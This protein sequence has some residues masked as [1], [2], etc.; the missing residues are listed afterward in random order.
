MVG[1][2]IELKTECKHCGNPLMLNALVTDILCPSCNK[3]NSFS[4]E[5]WQGLLEDSFEKIGEFKLG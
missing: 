2:C 5:T 1:I 4:I 3:I